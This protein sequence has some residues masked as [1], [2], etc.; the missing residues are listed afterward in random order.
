MRKHFVVLLITLMISGV[1]ICQ[2][3][4]RKDLGSMDF[5]IGIP[6][7]LNSNGTKV[8]KD[9]MGLAQ[10][11]NWAYG[12]CYRANIAPEIICITGLNF[13][14]YQ[15]SNDSVNFYA[16]M[17]SAYVGYGPNVWIKDKIN[18]AF[19]LNFGCVFSEQ[20]L[21]VDKG[22]EDVYNSY[23]SNE[24]DTY[25]N[26]SRLLF[27]LSI[28]PRIAYKLSERMNLYANGT[29]SFFNKR[30]LGTIDEKYLFNNFSNVL[31]GINLVL[32]RRQSDD[33]PEP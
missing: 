19:D 15:F 32:S 24:Q 33:H 20:Q 18:L 1:G 9:K 4:N 29:Y 22:I 16:S 5:G 28:S 25:S 3:P 8:L 10:K 31:V 30:K 21:Y 23:Y 6:Y 13:N 12:F 27:N 11:Y 14:N 2:T 17:Y 7:Y 26:R